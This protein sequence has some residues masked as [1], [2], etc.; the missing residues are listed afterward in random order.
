MAP[1]PNLESGPGALHYLNLLGPIFV[2]TLFSFIP[3]D[4]NITV[5]LFVIG[6]AIYIPF[7]ICVGSLATPASP[8]FLPLVLQVSSHSQTPTPDTGHFEVRD[9][10][11]TTLIHKDTHSF[12]TLDSQHP[13]PAPTL[14]NCTPTSFPRPQLLANL[15]LAGTNQLL[16]HIASYVCGPSSSHSNAWDAISIP[17]THL[18]FIKSPRLLPSSYSHLLSALV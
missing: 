10:R 18:P 15:S 3:H 6:E 2:S 5:A 11:N 12:I 9:S 14:A 13:L 16:P 17:N 7:L 8:S 1:G 4:R